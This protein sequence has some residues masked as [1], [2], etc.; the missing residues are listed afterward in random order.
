MNPMLY[1]L[2]P[3]LYLLSLS[4]AQLVRAET[5]FVGCGQAECDFGTFTVC[6]Y[7]PRYT[8]TPQTILQ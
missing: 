3:L 2:S 5:E 8:P 6:N 7:A 4:N 1:S